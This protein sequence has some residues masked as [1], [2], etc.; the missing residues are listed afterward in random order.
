MR[1]KR[2][3]SKCFRSKLIFMVF[4]VGLGL[5]AVIQYQRFDS[6]NPIIKGGHI[7]R[8]YGEILPYLEEAPEDITAQPYEPHMPDI[9]QKDIEI[10]LNSEENLDIVYYD[11]EHA[12]LIH[13]MKNENSPSGIWLEA[14]GIM[15][16]KR[17]SDEVNGEAIVDE[18]S[19]YKR[20]NR[21]II[22]GTKESRGLRTLE[23]S[24]DGTVSGR[25]DDARDLYG[26][27]ISYDDIYIYDNEMTLIRK[28]KSFQF[29]KS[30]KRLK[31]NQGEDTFPGGEIQEIN[32][33]YILDD[34][35]DLYYMYYSTYKDNPW[36]YFVKVA[37]NVSEISDRK[38]AVL[39]KI[40]KEIVY[41]IYKKDGKLYCGL[42]NPETEEKYGLCYGGR[43]EDSSMEK[44][45]FDIYALELNEENVKEGEVYQEYNSQWYVKWIYDAPYNVYETRRINGLD[46]RIAVPDKEVAHFEGKKI[47]ID[48]F[49]EV[50]KEFKKI[51]QKY[52][53][54]EF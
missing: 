8:A 52:E 54:N 1:E 53:N 35:Q 15:D 50:V 36:I 16:L 47:G 19:F 23:I 18:I 40:G 13:I 20:N 27:D 14:R 5:L 48:E 37:E 51:Y 45:D 29:Y 4:L 46:S 49:E 28:G 38:I 30:G 41:P 12:S 31:Q 9:V 44:I 33:S 26:T 21:I 6:P 10:M 22:Y 2:G 32:Y 11:I 43:T 17:M 34:R 39:S 24:L 42:S 3:L 7:Q 25:F